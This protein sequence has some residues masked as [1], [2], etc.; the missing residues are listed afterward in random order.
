MY[1]PAEIKA[2]MKA[3][4]DAGHTISIS[5]VVQQVL[6]ERFIT[7]EKGRRVIGE[8]FLFTPVQLAN[9]KF[10]VEDDDGTQA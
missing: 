4:Q 6:V 1:L 10:K 7:I 3:Y 2:A 5:R 9:M 8:P